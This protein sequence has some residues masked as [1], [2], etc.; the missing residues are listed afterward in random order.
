[1]TGTTARS[2]KR[3]YYSER[4]VVSPTIQARSAWTLNR[5]GWHRMATRRGDAKQEPDLF[6]SPACKH[7]DP[8][9]RQG[10]DGDKKGDREVS[11]HPSLII[12]VTGGLPR[13]WGALSCRQRRTIRR[14]ANEE[15][16]PIRPCRRRSPG[17]DHHRNLQLRKCHADGRYLADRQCLRPR[18]GCRFTYRYG[19]IRQSRGGGQ[20]GE[21]EAAE[22]DCTGNGCAIHIEGSGSATAAT[23][24]NGA[25][26]RAQHAIGLLPANQWWELL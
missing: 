23:P 12:C 24:D 21:T 11:P 1:M 4:A 14:I 17:A 8:P 2:A 3:A 19:H 25:R 18:V 9:E 5:S 15:A 20:E 22:N 26:C 10:R 6:S 16:K 7:I 13:L